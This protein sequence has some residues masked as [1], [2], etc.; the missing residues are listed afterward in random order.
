MSMTDIEKHFEFLE[1]DDLVSE[2]HELFSIKSRYIWKLKTIQD[3]LTNDKISF[4]TKFSYED[5]GVR[6]DVEVELKDKNSLMDAYKKVHDREVVNDI[7]AAVEYLRT[8]FSNAAEAAGNGFA[9]FGLGMW[10]RNRLLWADTNLQ[11][12]FIRHGITHPDSMSGLI[13]ES[14]GTDSTE[15]MIKNVLNRAEAD[16]AGNDDELRVS[17]I[18]GFVRNFGEVY[19]DFEGNVRDPL[20]QDMNLYGMDYWL[21]KARD[22]GY[23]SS[24]RISMNTILCYDVHERSSLFEK[25]VISDTGAAKMEEK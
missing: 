9:H 7:G 12:W 8:T 4:T 19:T 16:R 5:N 10:I 6:F 2:K 18:L 17:R 21:K 14:I 13:L 22:L 25:H 3:T 15:K 24:S 11:R 1:K 20:K 23:V